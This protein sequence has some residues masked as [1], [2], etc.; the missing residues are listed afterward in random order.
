AAGTFA[1]DEALQLLAGAVRGARDGDL[2]FEVLLEQERVLDRVG[3][4]EEQ[5]DVLDRLDEAAGDDPARRVRVLL[6]RGRWLFF[7]AGYA[8]A[9]PVAR[10]AAVVARAA[11][12]VEQE[13]EA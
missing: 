13:L 6:A 1:N 10:E 9:V 3:R 7:H 11:A 4:R 5:R 12:Q 2:V 8:E